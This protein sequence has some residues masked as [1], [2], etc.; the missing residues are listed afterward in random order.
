MVFQYSG[1][2]FQP[3]PPHG[4]LSAGRCTA[5]LWVESGMRS[6]TTHAPVSLFPPPARW[7]R[8][9]AW[10]LARPC[11]AGAATAA[12]SATSAGRAGP[13]ALVSP[14]QRLRPP[15]RLA[16]RHTQRVRVGGGNTAPALCARRDRR[17]H[18]RCHARPS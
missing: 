4:R 18:L 3:P 10:R 13:P 9:L 7:I 6:P 12:I 14:P 5:S 2:T 15:R 1:D 11:L 16:A 17:G 8:R